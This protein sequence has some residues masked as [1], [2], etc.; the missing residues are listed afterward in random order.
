MALTNRK[1]AV[2]EVLPLA[3][4]IGP[5]VARNS[6]PRTIQ[7]EQDGETDVDPPGTRHLRLSPAALSNCLRLQLAWKGYVSWKKL[8]EESAVF[9]SIYLR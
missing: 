1:R 7:T 3:N 9:F 2:S 5:V 6:H 4:H 8:N